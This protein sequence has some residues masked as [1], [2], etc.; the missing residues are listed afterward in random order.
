MA[1][2]LTLK[3]LSPLIP[4]SPFYTI[5]SGS[6]RVGG[7]SIMAPYSIQK[8]IDHTHCYPS[9]S[10]GHGG[11]GRP[12]ISMGIIALYSPQAGGTITPTN[13]IQPAKGRH[14]QTIIN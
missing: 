1:A 5:K 12:F 11:T 4:V 7:R 10:P 3:C 2:C 9:S 8:A 6:T 14:K 13:S